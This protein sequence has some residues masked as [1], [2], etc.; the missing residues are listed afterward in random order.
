MDDYDNISNYRVTQAAHGFVKG[1]VL[2]TAPTAGTYAKAQADSDSNAEV[3]G[4]VSEV[5]DANTFKLRVIGRQTGL[6]GLVADTVYFLSHVTAG[7]L[8]TTDP[9]TIASGFVSKPVLL[10]DSTTSGVILTYRG[11]NDGGAGDAGPVTLDGISD[12]NAPSPTDQDILTWDNASS[13]W[14]NQAAAGGGGGAWSLISTTNASASHPIEFTGLSSTYYAYRL[15]FDNCTVSS[16]N[17]TLYLRTSSNNGTSYDG[18]ATDY[19]Y[20]I[21]G[22]NSAN[23]A[24]PAR[25][26]GNASI[27]MHGGSIGNAANESFGGEIIIMNPSDTEYT[28][29]FLRMNF[30]SSNASEINYVRG[31]GERKSTTA[32]DAFSINAFAGTFTGTFK[33]YGLSAT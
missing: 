10:T 26:T 9:A 30:N 20:S 17:Q 8:T 31:V 12:V 22:M 16:D 7:A 4:I 28:K 15:V 3:C 21:E 14:I 23:V 6:S 13:K 25:N 18:G 11:I 27:I 19:Q 1:E 2:R 29:V 33:L 5:I 24:A 32:V